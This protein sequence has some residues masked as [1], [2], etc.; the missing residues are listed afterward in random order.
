MRTP[1]QWDDAEQVAPFVF[2]KDV[3]RVLQDMDGM[4]E[5]GTHRTAR[6]AAGLRIDELR[7]DRILDVGLDV[8]LFNPGPRLVRYLSVRRIHDP[9]GLLLH[10]LPQVLLQSHSASRRVGERV[11]P[12]NLG[13]PVAF[14]VRLS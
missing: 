7:L 11:S 4:P 12:P 14:N 2:E 6:K 13:V 5:R 1:V 9:A 10:R 3:A 8:L